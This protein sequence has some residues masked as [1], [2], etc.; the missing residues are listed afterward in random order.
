[1]A[2]QGHQ[3]PYGQPMHPGPDQNFLWNIFQK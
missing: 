2:Y 3:A 1:M